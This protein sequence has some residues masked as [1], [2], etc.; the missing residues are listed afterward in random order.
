MTLVTSATSR[1]DSAPTQCSCRILARPSQ[2][3]RFPAPQGAMTPG[4]RSG[5][6]LCGDSRFSMRA[7]C[8][9]ERPQPCGCTRQD[10]ALLGP[11]SMQRARLAPQSRTSSMHLCWQ[12]RHGTDHTTRDGLS[13]LLAA[14]RRAHRAS[15]LLL[16]PSLHGL[17]V[18]G[19]S[20]SQRQVG[21]VACSRAQMSRAHARAARRVAA[22]Y[23]V[24]HLT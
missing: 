19:R 21:I 18:D 9:G 22:A 24:A 12:A 16:L 20:S 17:H 3:K 13:W 11:Q 15:L 5:G 7:G 4:P 10:E 6:K 23:G 8:V 2:S 1:I 14:T